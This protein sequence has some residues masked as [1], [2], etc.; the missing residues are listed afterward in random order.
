M[1]ID[2]WVDGPGCEGTQPYKVPLVFLDDLDDYNDDCDND[3]E[4]KDWKSVSL[5]HRI[6]TGSAYWLCP[7]RSTSSV[8]QTSP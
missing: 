2:W 5:G 3:D 1:R 4:N 6:K 8:W 7:S